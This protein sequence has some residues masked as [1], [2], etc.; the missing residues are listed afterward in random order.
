MFI[1]DV[2]RVILK[3]HRLTLKYSVFLLSSLTISS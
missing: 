1:L 3:N 2:E